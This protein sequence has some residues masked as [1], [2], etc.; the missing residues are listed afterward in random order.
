MEEAH[1]VSKSSWDKL[2]P[3][4]RK[5]GSEIWVSFNPELDDDETY[6]RFVRNTPENSWVQQVSYKDNPW[7]SAEMKSEM[8]DTRLR[9][10]DDYQHIWLGLTKQTLEGSVYGKELRAARAEG[11]ITKVPYIQSEAV[12]TFWDLGHHGMTSIWFVQKVGF[13][14]HVIDF[15]ENRLEL[16]AHYV[17]VLQDKKYNYGTDYLPHDAENHHNLSE[18]VADQFKR[19]TGRKPV[20]LPRESVEHGINT[21]RTIFPQMWFD[22]D[23]CADGLHALRRYSYEV[24]DKTHQ[25]SQTPKADEN[26]HAADAL[27]YYAMSGKPAREKVKLELVPPS[28]KRPQLRLGGPGRAQHA[29]LGR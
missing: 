17:S 15:Y 13:E 14:H 2:A 6:K 18:S 1:T 4:I 24:D 29:W 28:A 20:V 8:R 12:N 10:E 26:T 7:V 19:L 23:K 16:L 25:F 27:R 3:T 22:E 5:P 9:S 21:L 11:R